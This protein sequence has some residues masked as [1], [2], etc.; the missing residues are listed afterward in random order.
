[1]CQAVYSAPECAETWYWESAWRD[2]CTHCFVAFDEIC[3]WFSGKAVIF[4]LKILKIL[5]TLDVLYRAPYSDELNPVDQMW[6]EFKDRW[7][8][9]SIPI[10]SFVIDEI[11][12]WCIAF[13]WEL[14]NKL[15]FICTCQLEP[16]QRRPFEK[17]RYKGHPDTTEVTMDT[18]F[19]YKQP[20]RQRNFIFV[21]NHR[22]YLF[23]RE[24][25]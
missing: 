1:M 8:Q 17:G 3:A 18:T 24:F 7:K 14:Y 15:I 5:K 10:K 22:S 23:Q 6:V 25:L 20:C 9:Y 13:A 21:H 4:E 16:P 19:T 12:F 2:I 11:I